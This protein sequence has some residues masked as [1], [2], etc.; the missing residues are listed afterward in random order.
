MSLYICHG[1]LQ[2]SVH[3]TF[4]VMGGNVHLYLSHVTEV[5]F[6]FFCYYGVNVDLEQEASKMVIV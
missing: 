2:I 6:V 4:P 3:I 5:V 1:Q